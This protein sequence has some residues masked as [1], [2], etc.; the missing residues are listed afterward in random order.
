MSFHLQFGVG[1]LQLL[2]GLGGV[3]GGAEDAQFIG[4]GQDFKAAAL[5][6][7]HFHHFMHQAVEEAGIDE[8]DVQAGDEEDAGAFH[9]DAVRSGGSERAMAQLDKFGAAR[10]AGARIFKHFFRLEIEEAH[11]HRAAAEDSFE[12]SFATAAAKGFFR[13]QRDDGVAAFPHAFACGIPP[14][15]DAVAQRP[16]AGQLVQFALRRGDARSHSVGVIKNADGHARGF[17][18]ER[19]GKR[20]LQRKT[21]YL[22]QVR[23][24]FD[25]AVANNSGKAD[26]DGLE[27]FF[28]GHFFDK[29]AEG[30]DNFFGVHGLQGIE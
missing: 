20:G 24:F 25:H 27:F 28:T 15:A 3:D 17:A 30:S 10:I 14:K 26:T 18:L 2:C 21:L 9:V 13:V 6:R 11:A 5:Q 22:L 23:G 19:N 8:L 7:T 29:V 12:V 4:G 1:P 16:D